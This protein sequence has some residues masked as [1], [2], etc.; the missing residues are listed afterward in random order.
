MAKTITA[1]EIQKRNPNRVNVHLDGEFAFGLARIV[2]AWL[3]V[4]QELAPEKI[5]ALLEA[6]AGEV[7]LQRAMNFLSYRARSEKEVIDNLRKHGT[8][9]PAITQ[10]VERLK[11]S[12]AINDEKFARMWRENR[13]ELKPRG[14][15][16]LQSELRRKGIPDRVISRTLENLD[17]A[18]LAYTA[19]LSRVKKLNAADE[20][21]F[22]RKMYGFLGRRGFGYETIQ[23]VIGRLWQE[24]NKER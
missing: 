16:A 6:D 23:E 22:K 11:T 15:Y 8:P 9:E 17:E 24:H 4:G 5:A 2:A 10:T 20:Q 19:G 18:G 3:K 12:G 13:T 7:A 1:L 21:E 14:A